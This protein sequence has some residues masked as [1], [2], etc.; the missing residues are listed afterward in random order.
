MQNKKNIII[1]LCLTMVVVLLGGMFFTSMMNK[2]LTAMTW[3]IKSAASQAK[4]DEKRS[5][6]W[7][8]ENQMIDTITE[9][10]KSVVSIMISKDIKFYMEDPANILWPGS[11]QN[12]TAKVGWWS[13]ILVSKDGYIITNK[14]V[15]EDK[16]AQYSVVLNDGTSYNVSKIWF[17]DNLD[18]AI[19]KIVDAKWDPLTELPAATII[20]MTD[21]VRIG[22]FAI[23]IGN[24]LSEYKNSVTMGII[25]ARNRELKIN[26]GKN[27]YIGLFQTD[28]PINAGNSGGPLL[29]IYGNVIGINTAIS[30]MA[31]GVAFALPITREFVDTTLKSIQQYEKIVRPLIGIA[32]VDITPDTQK[33]LK[34]TLENGVYVKDVFADLPAAVAGIKQ[35]DVI[36]AVD[37][38]PVNQKTP[39]L[40]QLYTYAPDTSVN[41]TVVRKGETLQI[42]VVL[43][44][45]AN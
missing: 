12:Q 19:L 11:I 2:K 24:S 38:K 42:A 35:G 31:Q 4:I 27:L 40:Y 36:T 25:S 1:N 41:L 45:N 8:F 3:S 34:L 29:D 21:E 39:F 18:I 43:W 14:H 5:A 6:L 32:Y 20:G 22:Q 16:S 17:D 26:Q 30:D 23:A 44:Q 9:A 13:W 15:V 33:Q 28:A 37:E 10:S 7:V